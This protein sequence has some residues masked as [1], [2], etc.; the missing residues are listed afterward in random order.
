MPA[1]MAQA[2]AV[3][4]PLL[5]VRET[6]SRG[7]AMAARRIR[8]TVA[9]SV[10]LI[11]GCFASAALIQMRLDRAHALDQAAR[12]T[13]VRSR[14]IAAH[15]STLLGRYVAIGTAFANSSGTAATAAAL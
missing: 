2:Q 13:D 12:C 15:L 3:L 5:A 6:L 7:F 8:L 10:V 4:H 11:A 9:L 1:L 14:E